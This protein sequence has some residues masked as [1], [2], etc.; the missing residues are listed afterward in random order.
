MIQSRSSLIQTLQKLSRLVSS[1]RIQ[2]ENLEER[3]SRIEESL[4]IMIKN[5][6]SIALYCMG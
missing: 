5:P 4:M 2:T 6:Y 3:I 1:L